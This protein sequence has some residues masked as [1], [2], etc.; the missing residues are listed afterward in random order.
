MGRKLDLNDFSADG[1]RV[2]MRVDFNVPLDANRNITDDTR[3]R[4][5]VPSISRVL[6]TGGSVVLMSHLGRPKGAIDPAFSLRPVADHLPDEW[7]YM[8]TYVPITEN[9][10]TQWTKVHVSRVEDATTV[11][12]T[13]SVVGNTQSTLNVQPWLEEKNLLT[14]PA[15]YTD[16]LPKGHIGYEFDDVKETTI[17]I[18]LEK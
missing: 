10:N 15:G 17:Q 4:A 14:A 1:R 2:L 13:I 6:D 9:G 18:V 16:Q 11:E 8:E 5:A 7:D 12:K 3:I